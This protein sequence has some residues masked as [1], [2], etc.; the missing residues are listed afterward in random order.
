MAICARTEKEKMK[1]KREQREEAYREFLPFQDS[2]LSQRPIPIP[3]PFPRQFYLPRLF[4]LAQRHRK[5]RL[6]PSHNQFQRRFADLVFEHF[7]PLLV[8][9]ARLG[10]VETESVELQ[11]AFPLCWE[12]GGL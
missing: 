7:P 5:Q 2:D 8:S 12:R 10:V 9:E 4:I 11:G 6:F 1:S 3:N